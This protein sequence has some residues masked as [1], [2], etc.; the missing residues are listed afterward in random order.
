MDN[1]NLDNVT[2]PN[3]LSIGVTKSNEIID[4]SDIANIVDIKAKTVES[5]KLIVHNSSEQLENLN[6]DKP[7]RKI[8]RRQIAYGGSDN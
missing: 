8:I 4:N 1:K 2:L 6:Y 7:Y 3:I 5:D